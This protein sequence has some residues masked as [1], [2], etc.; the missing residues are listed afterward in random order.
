MPITSKSSPKRNFVFMVFMLGG[1][2]CAFVTAYLL[3]DGHYLELFGYRTVAESI[4]VAGIQ[5]W[6]LGEVFAFVTLCLFL[7]AIVCA[8]YQ[9]KFDRPVVWWHAIS[10]FVALI[11]CLVT[12]FPA[13]F[14]FQL[15]YY[16]GPAFITYVFLS[17]DSTGIVGDKR[18]TFAG[19]AEV[20]GLDVY[21]NEAENEFENQQFVCISE[22]AWWWGNATVLQGFYPILDH[23]NHI[24]LLK[25]YCKPITDQEAAAR[26]L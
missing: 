22:R 24:S 20:E 1:P 15:R 3:T 8:L 4:P 12:F 21:Y 10:G 11:F 18:K 9:R 26:R 16:D 25:K 2:L 13:P 7:S 17:K 23:E 19:R 6:G 5:V 14:E